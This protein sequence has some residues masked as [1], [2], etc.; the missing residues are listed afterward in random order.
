MQVASIGFD[1]DKYGTSMG[2][3]MYSR[4]LNVMC[5]QHCDRLSITAI[6]IAFLF[7]FLRQN[8]LTL[9]SIGDVHPDADVKAAKV[10][11]AMTSLSGGL[12]LFSGGT[13]VSALADA[14]AKILNFITGGDEQ[15]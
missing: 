14:G 6:Q 3:P 9:L 11:D 4:L 8:V 10:K 5:L 13:F 2:V 1:I 7:G 15:Q 12:A